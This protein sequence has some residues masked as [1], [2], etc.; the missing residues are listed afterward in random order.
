ML[1]AVNRTVVVAPAASGPYGAE[2]GVIVKPAGGV[3]V[4]T[5][6]WVVALW[7][8]TRTSTGRVPP[9]GRVSTG[10]TM[11][12]RAPAPTSCAQSRNWA[13]CGSSCWVAVTAGLTSSGSSW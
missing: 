7:L 10:R 4:T 12:A 8:V 6:D 9:D 13:T 2:A 3:G 1:D 5:P 11:S